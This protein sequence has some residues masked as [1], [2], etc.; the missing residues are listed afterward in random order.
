MK[1]QAAIDEAFEMAGLAWLDLGDVINNTP[2]KKANVED[3]ANWIFGPNTNGKW[4]QAQGKKHSL[5]SKK[6]FE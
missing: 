2:D 5:P 1:V 4:A 6:H 3:L